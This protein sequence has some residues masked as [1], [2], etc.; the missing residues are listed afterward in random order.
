MKK[1]GFSKSSSQSCL[2]LRQATRKRAN[3][4]RYNEGTFPRRSRPTAVVD[5]NS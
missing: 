5:A 2:G 3:E 1:S 4:D